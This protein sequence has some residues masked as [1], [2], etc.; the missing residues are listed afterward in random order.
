MSDNLIILFIVTAVVAALA[1]PF[2]RRAIRHR[3]TVGKHSSVNTQTVESESKA[4][5][6]AERYLMRFLLTYT[7][8]FQS[9][10]TVRI[11]PEYVDQ[12]RKSCRLLRGSK[13]TVTA[14]VDKV[15]EDHFGQHA[16]TIDT[17][18][19]ERSGEMYKTDE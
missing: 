9:S 3:Q 1:V 6:A 2:I 8:P 15:L 19:A 18:H 17:L 16:D 4:L 10:K 14:Y 11:R 5:T 13:T 7:A 12:I